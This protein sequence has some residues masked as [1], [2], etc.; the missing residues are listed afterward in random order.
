MIRDITNCLWA[1]DKTPSPRE[2]GPL[3]AQ[4][5]TLSSRISHCPDRGLWLTQNGFKVR[6]LRAHSRMTRRVDGHG[7]RRR[8]TGQ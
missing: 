7:R 1:P 2:T 6:V 4:F 3:V 5:P 8:Y